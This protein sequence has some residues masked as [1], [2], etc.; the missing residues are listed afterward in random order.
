MKERNILLVSGVNLLLT[1]AVLAAAVLFVVKTTKPLAQEAPERIRRLAAVYEA[2]DLPGKAAETYERYLGAA[3]ISATE[4]ARIHYVLGNIYFEKLDDPQAALGHYLAAAD[5]DPQAAWKTEAEKRTIT[6]LEK[7]GRKRDAQNRLEEKTALINVAGEKNLPI[8]A[9]V[10]PHTITLSEIEGAIEMMPLEIRPRYRERERKKLLLEQMIREWLLYDLAKRNGLQED[11]LVKEQLKRSER[12]FLATL[13][14]QMEMEKKIKV[15]EQE[16]RE[17]YD[18]NSYK[19][20]DN[21]GKV[22]DFKDAR[23][24]VT[25]MIKAEKAKDVGEDLI[26]ELE[27]LEDIKIYENALENS[28]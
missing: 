4:E 2:N 21:Q 6:C 28:P 15:S 3:D 11:E 18:E 26:K 1:A 17:Y 20:M 22:P 7:L 24:V 27:K 5:M 25:M 10:G 16:I 8:V 9:K 23:D 19:L 14:F 13:A 12:M